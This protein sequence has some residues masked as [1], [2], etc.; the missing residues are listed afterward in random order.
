M[1]PTDDLPETVCCATDPGNFYAQGLVYASEIHRNMSSSDPMVCNTGARRYRIAEDFGGPFGP[2]HAQS[3]FDLMV[4]RNYLNTWVENGFGEYNAYIWS[5]GDL[6][7]SQLWEFACAPHNRIRVALV[8][9]PCG[10]DDDA[11]IPHSGSLNVAPP[12]Q[13]SPATPI[14]PG[15]LVPGGQ[16]IQPGG[17]RQTN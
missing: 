4:F 1:F 5:N 12:A 7:E 3:D 8:L 17:L 6:G 15:Q 16:P 14:R 11:C 2:W 9:C 10:V 13:T